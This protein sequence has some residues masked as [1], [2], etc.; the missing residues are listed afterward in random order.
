MSPHD[1]VCTGLLDESKCLSIWLSL[2]VFKLSGFNDNPF[3]T[4]ILC[5]VY[6]SDGVNM[7]YN[8][9]DWF[10]DGKILLWQY[11]LLGT[12]V[13]M[14][15]LKFV[16]RLWDHAYILALLRAKHEREVERGN[17]FLLDELLI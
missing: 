2:F 13:H 8:I 11:L 6:T 5:L 15:S 1:F 14:S 9:S 16:Q 7:L 10:N 12:V 3:M 4:F 17:I